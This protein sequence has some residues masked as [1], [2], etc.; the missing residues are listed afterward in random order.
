VEIHIQKIQ[1]LNLKSTVNSVNFLKL[2][3]KLPTWLQARI[4][5][6]RLTTW[7]YCVSMRI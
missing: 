6:M 3:T 1:E 4:T 2:M 5:Q 7:P